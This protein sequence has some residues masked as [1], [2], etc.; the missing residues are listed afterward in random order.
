MRDMDLEFSFLVMSLSGF[1]IRLMVASSNLSREV[2][3][4][5]LFALR[6]CQEAIWVWKFLFSFA[7]WPCH[8]AC[9]IFL[10]NQGWNQCPLQRLHR[11]LT[12]G[13]TGKSQGFFFKW[14]QNYKF[15]VFNPSM[16]VQII[17]FIMTELIV[18]VSEKLTHFMEIVRFVC[19]ELFIV[20]PLLA[21]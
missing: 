5:L 12:T 13:L 1:G 18:V 17:C 16:T 2:F 9:G 20:I 11:V 4:P 8:A 6:I 3:L 21:P 14:F 7:F 15:N 19:V 10:P